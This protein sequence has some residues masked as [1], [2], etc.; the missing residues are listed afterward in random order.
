MKKLNSWILFGGF[1]ALSWNMSLAQRRLE[2]PSA[3]TVSAPE[4]STLVPGD[5]FDFQIRFNN[6]PD[7]YGGG[8]ITYVLSLQGNTWLGMSG[9]QTP[10][11]SGQTELH[12][13]QAIYTFSVPIIDAMIPGTWKLTEVAL[14]RTTKTSVPVVDNVSFVIPAVSALHIHVEAPATVRAGQRFV[15]KVDFKEPPKARDPACSLTVQALLQPEVSNIDPYKVSTKPIEAKPDVLSYELSGD[16]APDLPSGLWRG[17]VSIVEH[18]NQ[19]QYCRTPPLEGDRQ[20]SFLVEN[21]PGLVT[22][23]SATVIVNPSQIQLLL[24]EADRLKA[25]AQHLKEQLNAETAE[26]NQTLLRQ[27]L[28]Q[29]ISDV[30]QTEAKFKQSVEPAS[31]LAEVNTFFDDIRFDYGEA[32]KILMEDSSQ[33]RFD[34]PGLLSVSAQVGKLTP[35]LT[36]ASATVLKTILRTAQA[37]DLVAESKTLTFNLWVY[38]VPDGAAISYWLRG[39]TPHTVDH[40]TDWEIENLTRAVYLIQVQKSGY[41]PK[42]ITFDAINN[43]NTSVKI[44]LERSRHLR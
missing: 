3:A 24:G 21:N 4:S 41:E 25:R 31:S 18:S 9:T 14:E 1:C 16:F 7:G 10:R 43:Q 40:E 22:P 13:G 37:Y 15:F 39:G 33:A 36:R 12:D 5:V 35:H 17:E 6:A 27:S 11:M 42:E 28:K 29:S 8:Y 23:T 30:D 32:L 2:T 34:G 38:S 19:G 20:F 26:G 44:P